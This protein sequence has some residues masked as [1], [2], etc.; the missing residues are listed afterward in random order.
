MFPVCGFLIPGP[1]LPEGVLPKAENIVWRI[2]CII[3]FIKTQN[4]IFCFWWRRTVTWIWGFIPRTRGLKERCEGEGGSTPCGSTVS[5]AHTFLVVT[6]SLF[7]S[8]VSRWP[9]GQPV[10]WLYTRVCICLSPHKSTPKLMVSETQLLA[11]VCVGEPATCS[12]KCTCSASP[13]HV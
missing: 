3:V 8:L 11:S 4:G 7:T 6:S 10:L 1:Q 2:C 5:G 9:H 13:D 12:W